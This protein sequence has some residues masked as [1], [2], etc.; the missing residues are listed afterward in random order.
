MSLDN[1]PDFEAVAAA[2][3]TLG[4]QTPRIRNLFFLKQSQP[5]DLPDCDAMAAAYTSISDEFSRAAHV[6][7]GDALWGHMAESFHIVAE[8][9]RVIGIQLSRLRNAAYIQLDQPGV[10]DQTLLRKPLPDFDA[11]HRAYVTLSI[12]NP[13]F[14]SFLISRGLPTRA[15]AA[16]ERRHLVPVG[17]SAPFPEPSAIKEAYSILE[18]E[19]SLVGNLFI[20]PD[21]GEDVGRQLTLAIR[22]TTNQGLAIKNPPDSQATSLDAVALEKDGQECRNGNAE[23]DKTRAK[24]RRAYVFHN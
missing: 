17:R 21:K 5:D 20:V 24:N 12:Q 10:G 22:N 4:I 16:G 18:R 8:K 1:P 19:Y 15:I 13:R 14:G 9:Y 3:I 11:M 6:V 2:Y 7:V 23:N